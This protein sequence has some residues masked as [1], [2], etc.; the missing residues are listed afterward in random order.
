MRRWWLVALV[1]GIVQAA[2]PAWVW[3]RELTLAKEQNYRAMVS[4][5]QVQKPLVLRWTLYK[6]Y[7]LVMHIRYDSFNHQVVLYQDYQRSDF[8]LGLGENPAQ[9]PR[10]HIFF[11]DFADKKALLRLYIEGE[12]ASIGEENL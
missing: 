11:K 2:Q 3:H 6:N 9:K 8:A 7:G 5:A 12:G 4:L 10:L 1:V